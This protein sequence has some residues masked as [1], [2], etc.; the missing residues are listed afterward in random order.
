MDSDS[1]DELP[2][3]SNAEGAGWDRYRKDGR[4]QFEELFRGPRHS[5]FKP[6]AALVHM[7]REMAP[8]V[9]QRNGR[10]VN[11]LAAERSVSPARITK[12]AV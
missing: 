5:L 11:A 9:E 10:H 4:H 6:I 7:L 12:S 2:P 3:S 8:H 1:L